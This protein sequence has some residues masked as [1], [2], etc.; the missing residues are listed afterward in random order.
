MLCLVYKWERRFALVLPRAGARVG[1]NAH[2][3]PRGGAPTLH[4][5]V[6][7]SGTVSGGRAKST[8]CCSSRVAWYSRRLCSMSVVVS[9]VQVLVGPTCRTAAAAAARDGRVGG[10]PGRLSGAL[11]CAPPVW[12]C[13]AVGV[14]TGREG[15]H[16]TVLQQLGGTGCCTVPV[17]GLCGAAA[18]QCMVGVPLG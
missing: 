2:G 13:L 12:L 18:T 9:R 15:I 16:H 5:P 4:V 14:L 6:P 7:G 11:T 17:H 8:H 3:L 10:W 1:R